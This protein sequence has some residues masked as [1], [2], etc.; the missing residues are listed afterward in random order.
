MKFK[1]ISLIFSA[2]I[3]MS[4]G[5]AKEPQKKLEESVQKEVL[6]VEKKKGKVTRFLWRENQFDKKLGS[7]VSTIF[8]N[9]D[10]CKTISKPEK[11][12]LAFVA[13]F[14]GSECDWDGEVKEDR[15]NLKCKILT[16]L[17]LSY[18][19]SENHLGFLKKS[20][21]GDEKV[22]IKLRENCPTTPF[23]ATVQETFEE[24][25]LTTK[26]DTIAVWFKASGVNLREQ[27]GW[28]WSETNYFKVSE[29]NLQ[30]VKTDKSEV[31]ES[32]F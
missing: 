18:Q 22:L 19:C 23:T 28:S 30:L 11:A 29:Q 9:E 24:I 15:S 17:N 6:K 32:S 7:E 3:L 1:I 12:A 13:T 31:E 10:F 14:I 16:A 8:I 26:N 27:R 21:V 2:V 20:F 4:C 5:E 25:V